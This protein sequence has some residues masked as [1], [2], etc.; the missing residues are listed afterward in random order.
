MKLFNQ[1]SAIFGHAPSQGAKTALFRAFA[2]ALMVLVVA[3]CGRDREERFIAG[4]IGFLYNE[5]V[6][7]LERKRYERAAAFFNEVERQYPYS[8]WARRAQLMAAY[9]YY[10][11]NDYDEAIL[12]VDRFLALH[13][14]NPSAPYA[15]Y[16]K[17][18][19]YYEQIS[20]VGRDQGVTQQA[21]N[22]L[23][24]VASRF[25]NTPYARDAEL[26]LDL[27][28]DHLAGK[29]MEIG[30]FYQKQNQCVAA[31]LRFRNVIDEYQTTTHAPEALHRMVEC[32]LVMGIADEA[33]RVAAVLGHNF[34]NSKWYR[35]TY[36][37]LTNQNLNPDEEPE[38]KKFL[39]I[40]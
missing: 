1:I 4:E 11:N 40:F 27:T 9:A 15:Y 19:S 20:D 39:G 17:A 10:M 13:P 18:I 8:E 30:R 38:R 31:L 34:P 5:G 14:G 29:E 33:T 25:P 24:E 26:K 36:T 22:A 37:L 23:R 6:I 32:Y 2:V 35:Y 16:L 28:R 3:A 12:G 21:L 7:Q